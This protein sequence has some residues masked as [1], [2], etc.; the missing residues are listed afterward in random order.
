MREFPLIKFV[1]LFVVGI[2][3]ESLISLDQ[4]TI[5]IIISSL[6]VFFLLFF[7]LFKA[8]SIALNNLIIAIII[9]LSGTYISRIQN[10]NSS[11]LLNKF[12]KE[13]NVYVFGKVENVELI[14]SF[15]VVFTITTD[16]IFIADSLY[17]VSEKILCKYRGDSLTRKELYQSLMPGNTVYLEGVFQ[18]GREQRNPGEFDYNKYLIEN[19]ISGLLISYEGDSLNI[20]NNDEAFFSSLIFNIRKNIDKQISIIFEKN[21]AGL[22]RGL[23]LADRADIDFELKTQFINAGVIHVLAVS[24]LHVGYI[25]LI[26]IFLFGRFNI[27]IRTILTGLGL[28]LFMFITGVPPSVF[29]ATLMAIILLVSFLSNRSTN[30]LNSLSFAALIILLFDTAEIYNP[31]FQLSFS[32]VLSIGI[33]YPI[34]EREIKKLQINNSF[35]RGILLFIGVSLSAQIGTLPFTVA[36]FGKLSVVA[37]FTNLLVIPAIGIIICIAFTSLFVSLFS[38]QIALYFAAVNDLITDLLFRIIAF[39]GDFKYSFIWISD[40][41]IVDGLIFYFFISVLIFSFV[42]S[43]RLL[44]KLVSILLI[45]LN[46]I[47]FSSLDDYDLLPDGK[48]S[49]LMIDV[50]QGDAILIK[51]PNNKTALIDAGDVNPFFDNGERI[52]TPLLRYLNIKQIDYGFITHLDMDHYGGFVTLLSNGMVK[53]IFKPS[54]D[55]SQKDIRLEKYLSHIKIP[56]NYFTRETF[57]FGGAK[58]YVLNDDKDEFYQRLSS[59]DK[60]GLLKLVYG[61]TSILFTGDIEKKAESFYAYKYASFLDSD[62]L[63]VAH[64]GSKTSSIY[65]FLDYVTPEISLIS[66][67]FKNQFRHP[68]ND[69]LERLGEYQSA[70]YRTDISGAILFQSDG[71]DLKFINWKDYSN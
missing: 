38:I 55:T 25:L 45:A 51:F 15:E 35:L 61:E 33:I 65:E 63:K 43:N 22:I 56:I 9:L 16:S 53:E 34:L 49:V 4:F 50:G 30:L 19:R 47:I 29:R 10:D 69:I 8:Q 21:T 36:Y 44:I 14:K 64:H 41:S 27:Y 57:D 18:K 52:V 71:K 6:A 17:R 3:I 54:P 70:I 13:K 37:L 28:I 26:F 58:L 42:V 60:S 20:V 12:I 39:A 24:G 68:A 46:A 7:I 59:N 48:L 1:L 31:G 40:Y 5:L 23:L 66:A 32:A 2:L 67:G 62:V 11:L